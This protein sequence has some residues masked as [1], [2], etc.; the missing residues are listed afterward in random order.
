MNKELK[1]NEKIR[2]I[3]YESLNKWINREKNETVFVKIKK[4]KYEFMVL[5]KSFISFALN[6]QKE[7]T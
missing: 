7:V 6:I 1:I 3:F 4:L 2:T 5:S